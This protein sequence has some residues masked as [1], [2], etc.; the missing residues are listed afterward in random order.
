MGSGV[1]SLSPGGTPE[2]VKKNADLF[3]HGSD[4]TNRAAIAAILDWLGPENLA[5]YDD[6]G[7]SGRERLNRLLFVVEVKLFG[8][9]NLNY[10]GN[11]NYV[12][13]ESATKRY[14]IQCSMLRKYF[15]W[16]GFGEAEQYDF[17]IRRCENDRK[18]PDFT[19]E[20]F[21]FQK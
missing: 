10:F 16:L 17:L 19:G 11:L 21:E 7:F 9:Q 1:Y 18:N 2:F 20:S 15:S 8:G 6:R 3:V 5:S 4:Q 12:Y 14:L 13:D